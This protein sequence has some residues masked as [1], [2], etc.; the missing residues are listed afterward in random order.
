MTGAWKAALTRQFGAAIDTLAA[1][2]EACPDRL[3][4]DRSQQPPFWHIAY[5]TLFYLDLYLSASEDSFRPPACH[6][7]NAN[8]L[9]AMPFPPFHVDTPA[10]ACTK[11]ELRAY[12]AAGRT[13]CRARIAH[14]TPEEIERRSPFP[15]LDF[16]VGDLVLYNMRHVQHHAAQLNLRLRAQ[17]IAPPPWVGRSD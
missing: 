10:V 8:F 9:G 7:Q 3:W 17:G 11:E 6:R 2:I 12:L 5:H 15:W 1:A 14:L 16:T 13:R 4:D